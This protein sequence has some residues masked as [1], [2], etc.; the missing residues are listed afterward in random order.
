MTQKAVTIRLDLSPEFSPKTLESDIRNYWEKID[1]GKTVRKA[2]AEKKPIGFVE[3]PP[4]MNGDPHIGHI[5]GRIMKDLWYRFSTLKGV[6]VIF[7]GGWDTQGLP[8]ELQAEKELGLTGSKA[9]NLRKIGP[10]KLVEACK[11]LVRG[12][13]KKWREADRLLGMSMDYEKAY[14]TYEDEYIEREWKY[15]E[16]AWNR[17]L[18]GEG[19][20]VVAYCPSCQTSLSHT[21]V[22]LGYEL[23]N[24]PSVYFKM[25]LRDED[26]YLILWTTMPFTVVTDEIVG[27]KTNADYSYVKVGEETWI[28]ASDRVVPLMK[29]LKVGKYEVLKT[30]VGEKLEGKRYTHPLARKIPCQRK[31]EEEGLVHTIVAEDFVDTT[32]GTGLV[33]MS[34]ANGEKDFEVATKRNLP[35]INPIDD[36]VRFTEEAGEYRGVFVRDCDEKIVADLKT[37]GSLLKSGQVRHEYPTC[38][39]SHHKLV[40]LAR[41]E[42]F[43][44]VNKLGNMAIEAAEEVEYFYEA[45]KNRFIGIIKDKVPWNISR[46]RIWGSPIPI[47]VCT[48]CQEKIPAFSRETITKRAVELPDGPDFELHRPWIDRVVI[49]CTK[50]EGKAL[51]EPFVLDTW[52]NSGASPYASFTDA[53]FS[54]IIPVAFLTEGI[55]QT[56][57]WAHSLLIEHVLFEG[58][59]KAPYKAFL[60]QGHVLDENGEKMS[61]S[62]GNMV[63]GLTALRNEPVDIIRYYLLWKSS[64]ID[65]LNFSLKE[66]KSRPYQVLGTLYH[67]HLFFRV[68]SLYDKFDGHEQTLDWAHQQHALR[69]QDRWLLSKVQDLISEVTEAYEKCRFHEGLRALERF[70]IDSL[71]QSYIP[72]TRSEIWDDAP[73]TRNRRLAIYATLDY[74][75]RT[76]DLLFHP[77]SPYLT[78][79]LYQTCF[80]RNKSSHP[81]L[82]ERWPAVSSELRNEPVEKELELLNNVVSVI[83]AARMKAKLKRRWPLSRAFVH[84]PKKESERLNRNIAVL[85]EQTNIKQ[86]SI[87]S[88]LDELPLKLRVKPSLKELGTALREKVV[89]LGRRLSSEN[90]NILYNKLLIDGNVTRVMDGKKVTLTTKEIGFSLEPSSDYEASARDGIIAVIS[91]NRSRE[92]VAEGAV[93]DLAR[94]LQS[95]RKERGYNP[96]E[97]LET[98]FVS[99][100]EDESLRLIRSGADLLKHLV[101]VKNVKLTR[102]PLKGVKWVES[103]IDGRPIKISIE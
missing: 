2:L 8:V 70:V 85:L 5:R 36:Q 57:G 26:T 41:R 9:E 52:H 84:L 60:F 19:F 93:R 37:E 28:V 49:A 95:L 38:W 40:W 99:E 59:P 101:R 1:V 91:T 61:K 15:L 55:D 89:V 56:R 34:P 46:E 71:S 24:D 51:R 67:L 78:E 32:T 18:L 87:V 96:T 102:K 27:V 47:W 98:A 42:Y 35:I 80:K 97:I 92:L 12:Y 48:Q 90:P 39:R 43:Y 77:A 69:I 53:E 25:K 58:R 66:M 64:P 83:N 76:L 31:L 75:L 73:N 79:Y 21:E 68:N 29:D 33:H 10:E 45:P 100:L 54:E 62:R 6:N 4:T 65:S 82:L 23:V 72:M 74:V 81:I 30:V 20:R 11:S 86:I 103:E 50:C 13:N 7:R 14:W 3:G 88:N 17:G 63:E 44:W 94:R 22:S 16:K